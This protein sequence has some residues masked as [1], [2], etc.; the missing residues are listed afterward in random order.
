ME[1]QVTGTTCLAESVKG[2][3]GL[4]VW[5]S[6]YH[7]M[8]PVPANQLSSAGMLPISIWANPYIPRQ[9][10]AHELAA[11]VT[12]AP[13]DRHA[14]HLMHGFASEANLCIRLMYQTNENSTRL[15]GQQNSS[16]T[17]AGSGGSTAA[18][19]PPYQQIQEVGDRKNTHATS[20]K[21]NG[22]Q[23]KDWIISGL[24]VILALSFAQHVRTLRC[25]LTAAHAE[26][27]KKC[28]FGVQTH[29]EAVQTSRAPSHMSHSGRASK[30]ALGLEG[31]DQQFS[32][33]QD[34]SIGDLGQAASMR[35]QK[36]SASPPSP[37]RTVMTINWQ[38]QTGGR[39]IRHDISE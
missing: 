36:L 33:E 24:A 35:T 21:M 26:R 17:A 16:R 13:G 39:L 38:R 37:T 19:S 1:A 29:S 20:A 22:T 25:C 8:A 14:V 31:V 15:Q 10:V 7:L 5:Q 23:F 4:R 2:D 6:Q 32:S 18:A 28:A 30:S 9:L 12:T 27:A 34:I 11:V 3:S